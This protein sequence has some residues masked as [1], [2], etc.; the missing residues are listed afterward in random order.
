MGPSR[1]AYLF[2]SRLYLHSCCVCVFVVVGVLLVHTYTL[3]A[4]DQYN[5]RRH[6]LGL[7]CGTVYVCKCNL[8]VYF[9]RFTHAYGAGGRACVCVRV[10]VRGNTLALARC[11]A[12]TLLYTLS[13]YGHVG[14]DDDGICCVLSVHMVDCVS[15]HVWMC[16]LIHKASV[17]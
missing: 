1:I 11:V 5:R 7:V 3:R 8:R 4:C 12:C 6:D 17:T 14:P 2:C 10:C 13:F 16:V 15:V 9:H